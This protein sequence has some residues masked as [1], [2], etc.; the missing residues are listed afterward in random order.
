MEPGIRRLTFVVLF[1]LLSRAQL[2]NHNDDLDSAGIS[3]IFDVCFESVT[4]AV[5]RGMRDETFEKERIETFKNV[6]DNVFNKITE[7]KKEERERGA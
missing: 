5:N 4:E 3:W 2:P 7:C 6:I 1:L